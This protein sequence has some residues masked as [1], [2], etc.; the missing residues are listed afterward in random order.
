MT[1]AVKS[2]KGCDAAQVTAMPTQFGNGGS[3]LFLTKDKGLVTKLN[4]AAKA[5]PK[6]AAPMTADDALA[7]VLADPA[8]LAK[9]AAALKGGK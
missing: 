3:I 9:L 1:C 4:K 7:M 5:K 2:A 6:G 8:A